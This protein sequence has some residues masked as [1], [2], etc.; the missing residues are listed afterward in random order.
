[1]SPQQRTLN[2]YFLSHLLT[3]FQI[4]RFCFFLF[5]RQSLVPTSGSSFIFLPPQCRYSQSQL[6]SS[7]SAPAPAFQRCHPHSFSLLSGCDLQCC[8]CLA[9]RF[10]GAFS[11][12]PYSLKRSFFVL[13]TELLSESGVEPGK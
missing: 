2:L 5:R 8:P 4:F 12:L 13:F 6:F 3:K 7:S 9:G 10:G 1:M 11:C